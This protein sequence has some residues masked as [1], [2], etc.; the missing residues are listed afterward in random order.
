MT[1]ALPAVQ[2]EERLREAEAELGAAKTTADRLANEVE[3]AR[4][5]V[6]E[7]GREPVALANNPTGLPGGR[8]R[9][10]NHS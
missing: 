1:P 4:R 10:G 7:V 3:A 2:A 9:L 8:P 5:H 6:E